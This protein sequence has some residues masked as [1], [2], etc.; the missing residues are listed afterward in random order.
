MTEHEVLF[1]VT[2][3]IAN[4]YNGPHCVEATA[5]L[6]ES[7]NLIGYELEAHAVSLFA[8]SES[9]TVATG[10]QGRAF[11][12]NWVRQRSGGL[13]ETAGE[14]SGGTPFQR[15]A[16]HMIAV[17]ADQGLLLDPT[18]S[19]FQKLG[20]AARPLFAEEAEL[21]LNKFW[22]LEDETFYARWY[23]EDDYMPDD[24]AKVRKVQAADAAEIVKFVRSK[25]ATT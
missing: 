19:Q 9:G 7:G 25:L 10:S 8:S 14:F 22:K 18:F 5:T 4:M 11:G 20:R 17:A 12:E 24:F 2:G 13:L 16:G 23:L 15:N 6:V 3:V 21:R 1:A